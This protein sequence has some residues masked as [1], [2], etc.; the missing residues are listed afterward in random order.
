MEEFNN[1]QPETY[2]EIY[3][4]KLDFLNVFTLWGC[5]FTDFIGTEVL[6]FESRGSKS[7]K[8]IKLIHY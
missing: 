2:G 8:C 1:Q 3:S 5:R 7:F 6:E 4:S